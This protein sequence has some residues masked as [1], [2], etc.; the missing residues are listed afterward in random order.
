MIEGFTGGLKVIESEHVKVWEGCTYKASYVDTAIASAASM[1][2]LIQIPS[3]IDIMHIN[4]NTFKTTGA[5]FT[6]GVYEGP[7]F[8]AAGAPITPYN[9]NR[10]SDNT[11]LIT[12]T[13]TPTISDDGTQIELDLIT[14]E[15]SGGGDE[16][17]YSEHFVLAGGTNYLFRTTNI[18][19]QEKGAVFRIAWFEVV[20]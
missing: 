13:H 10:L 17:G 5:P 2:I 4:H 11:S 19:G 6:V 9:I 3:T 16:E 20:A 12:V 8:S 1:D 14:G 15:K 18:T 7:T